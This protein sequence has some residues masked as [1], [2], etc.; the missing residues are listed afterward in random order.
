MKLKYTLKNIKPIKPIKTIKTIKTIKPIKHIITIIILLIIGILLLS[1]LYKVYNYFSNSIVINYPKKHTILPK[2]FPNNTYFSYF[3]GIDKKARHIGNKSL[4]EIKNYYIEHIID[5]TEE[6][7]TSLNKVIN[8]IIQNLS[9]DNT[10]LFI[11]KDWNFIKFSKIE[12]DFPHTHEDLIFIPQK[13]INNNLNSTYNRETLIHEKV[14]IFQRTA[15]KLF[16]NLYINYWNFIKT[17]IKNLELIQNKMRTNPDGLDNN[18]VFSIN[19]THILLGSVYNTN[20]T[21]IGDT[22]NYGIFLEKNTN[23]GKYI[24][25][26]K[27]PLK[28]NM[29]EINSIHEFTDFFGNINGNNYHPNEISAEIIPKHIFSNM[30]DNDS[31]GYINFKKWWN[32]IDL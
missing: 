14:H 26:V 1:Y 7:K 6:E 24:Y 15:P 16:E 29:K 17:P 21:H 27:T 12:N 9:P 19:N 4:S 32:K 10:K 8:S 13:M 25:N 3:N 20:P 2:L 23:N 5:F 31:K 30:K 28:D 22:K 11:L 18:W